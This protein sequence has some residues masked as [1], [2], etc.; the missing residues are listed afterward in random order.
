MRAEKNVKIQRKKQLYTV[1]PPRSVEFSDDDDDET[2]SS[3][4]HVHFDVL[5]E[6]RLCFF[7]SSSQPLY[8]MGLVFS[9]L[10]CL[11]SLESRP[12]SAVVP[13]EDIRYSMAT[14]KKNENSKERNRRIID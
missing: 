10:T 6:V 2:F 4:S 3:M 9:F 1:P 7:E 13:L 12:T 11:T 14:E 5:V 8:S